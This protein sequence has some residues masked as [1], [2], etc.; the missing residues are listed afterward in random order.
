MIVQFAV[1]SISHLVPSNKNE[2]PCVIILRIISNL[3][4]AGK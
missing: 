1:Y 4:R 2:P 3:N